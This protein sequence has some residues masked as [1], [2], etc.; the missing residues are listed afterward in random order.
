MERNKLI[1]SMLE[2]HGPALRLFAASWS[3]WPDDCVQRALIKLASCDPL[4]DQP[5]AWV[6]RVT[7]NEAINCRK[8]Q[9][10]RKKR[11]RVVAEER[12]LFEL[13]TESPIDQQEL[14]QAL[15]AL[16]P[17]TRAIVIAKIW[18]GLTFEQIAEQSGCS[19]SAAHR[20]YQTG[21]AKLK[22]KLTETIHAEYQQRPAK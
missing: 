18:G 21:L 20:K 7:R 17:E 19:S 3:D 9:T 2:Q 1:T 22:N 14:Q 12:G 4:P 8:K 16:N 6:Y 13:A 15:A 11:E 5:L 10:R